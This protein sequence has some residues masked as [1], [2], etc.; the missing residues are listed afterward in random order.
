MAKTNHETVKLYLE[1]AQEEL[2]GAQYNFDGGYF[3]IAISRAYYAFFYAATVLLLSRDI[4]RNKHSAVL[5][6]FR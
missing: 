1:S 4:L 6:A 5:A 2:K 3:S